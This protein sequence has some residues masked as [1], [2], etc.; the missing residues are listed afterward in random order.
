MITCSSP[1]EVKWLTITSWTAAYTR[2]SQTDPATNQGWL[3]TLSGQGTKIYENWMF[4]TILTTVILLWWH[5][6]VSLS[7]Q[8]PISKSSFTFRLG[9]LF[10]IWEPSNSFLRCSLNSLIWVVAIVI[11][12]R[13]Y[14]QDLQSIMYHYVLNVR[15]YRLQATSNSSGN[16][17][18][19]LAYLR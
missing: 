2:V 5:D 3:P 8:T 6:F 10:P 17:H 15:F 7:I 18:T 11:T 19:F 4:L 16:I 9:F 14:N 12:T 13:L 1:V